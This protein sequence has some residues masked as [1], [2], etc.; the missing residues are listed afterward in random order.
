MV[1]SVQK[2]R[3]KGGPCGGWGLNILAV[4][5]RFFMQGFDFGVT[6]YLTYILGLF[7]N[8]H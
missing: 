1:K 4:G 5:Q 3:K 6:A 2:H 8:A 7:Q